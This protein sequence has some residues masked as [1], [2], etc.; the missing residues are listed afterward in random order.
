[1]IE[2]F[3]SKLLFA[4][5]NEHEF[6]QRC[7][8]LFPMLA[9]SALVVRWGERAEK[10]EVLIDR[11]ITQL[12]AGIRE[13]V[14]LAHLSSFTKLAGDIEPQAFFE[15]LFENTGLPFVCFFDGEH[16]I[17]KHKQVEPGLM[18]YD[19]K[20][21][22]EFFSAPSIGFKSTGS[23]DYCFWHSTMWLRTFLN[24]PVLSLNASN[25]KDKYR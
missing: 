4:S 20:Q 19:S 17:E 13:R 1:M 6:G 25:R 14:L 21:A 18:S 5:K 15:K 16:L 24:L 22:Q 12:E 3:K 23:R 8:G 10:I 11:H 7:G 9:D 2:W